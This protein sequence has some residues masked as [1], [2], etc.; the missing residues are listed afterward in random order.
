M[1]ADAMPRFPANFLNAGA[2]IGLVGG[3]D[4]STGKPL[5]HYCLTGFWVEDDSPESVWEALVNRRT[6]A[7]SNGKVSIWTALNGMPM[8]SRLPVEGAVSID[9]SASA[10]REITR[11]CLI[12]DGEALGWTDIYAKNANLTLVDT[13]AVS[14][15]HWY[16]VTVEGASAYQEGEGIGR[17][18]QA[19]SVMAH[20]SP[21]FVDI[22]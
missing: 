22:K 8:G 10:A 11:V 4:H 18:V 20:S 13:A 16:V 3:T 2:V 1:N 5:N 12:R 6:V 17:E 9:I 19:A 14:G 15:R 7:C 21:Y